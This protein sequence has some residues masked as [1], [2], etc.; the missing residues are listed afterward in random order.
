MLPSLEQSTLIR[1]HRDLGP[2]FLFVFCPWARLRWAE[3]SWAEHKFTDFGF[4]VFVWAELTVSK[5]TKWQ[6]IVSKLGRCLTLPWL[7]SKTE[8]C[9][10]GPYLDARM[11]RISPHTSLLPS[12]TLPHP[13]KDPR[14]R[15]STSRCSQSLDQSSMIC[16]QVVES[17]YC[18]LCDVIIP[19]VPCAGFIHENYVNK[20]RGAHWE[21]W[22]AKESMDT[23]SCSRWTHLRWD[24]ALVKQ[25]NPNTAH[26]EHVLI[27]A[28]K[29]CSAHLISAYG[30]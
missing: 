2:V 19:N 1:E 8:L 9:N 5:L 14:S 15:I 29:A 23:V 26:S 30:M 18:L 24:R 12:H 22:H 4:F 27:W 20:P 11:D 16:R 25:K 13:Q 28:R 17:N 3:I 10:N 6:V 21:C 7:L